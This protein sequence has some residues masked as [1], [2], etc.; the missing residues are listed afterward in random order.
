M[1]LIDAHV[2]LYPPAANADPAAWAAARGESHWAALTTRRRKDRREVQAFPSAEEL[3]RAMD[4]A[5]V[6][7]AVLLG[8]YW[9]NPATCAEQNRFYAECVRSRPDRLTAFATFHPA[10]GHDEALAEV[11]RARDEGLCGLGELSPHSQGYSI[12]DET[13]GAV[14]ALAGELGLPVNLHVTDPESGAYPGRVGTP[15]AD[16]TRLAGKF[17]STNFILAHWGGLLPLRDPQALEFSN[18]YYD[19]AA[20]PLL[21]AEEIWRR[22]LN[23]VPKEQVLFGSDYPLNLYPRIDAAPAMPR[24]IAEFHRAGLTPDELRA[25]AGGNF[26]RLLRL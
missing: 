20:S 22:F 17:P 23:V 1:S 16:F 25:L 8:W 24:M 2:H 15:L 14:L 11:R 5:G 7:R 13:F 21:Y 12:D 19:T 10:A 9:E 6:A 3:L 26:R 18:L 4:A